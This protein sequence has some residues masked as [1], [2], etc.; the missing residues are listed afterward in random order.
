MSFVNELPEEWRGVLPEAMRSSG[1]LESVKTVEGLAK[2]AIDGRN[3]ASTALRIPSEDASVED[4]NAFNTD[5][6]SKMPN[7]V[8]MP[9]EGEDSAA[10]W[11]KLGRPADTDGYGIEKIPEQIQKNIAGLMKAGHDVGLSKKQME[12]ITK[13]IIDDFTSNVN[14]AKGRAEED[15]NKLKGEWGN[16]YQPK[17][18]LIK[19]FAEQTGFSEQFIDAIDDGQI[20]SKDMKAFDHIIKGFSGEGVN[21]GK[22]PG[23]SS[24]T[25]TP[26]EA[27]TRINEIMGNKD[28]AYWNA[29]DPSHKAAIDKIIALGEIAEK[30]R[31]L[32]ETERFRA[33]L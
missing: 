16:G 14:I 4:R 2:M 17:V 28:H 24:A 12:G 8:A 18:D 31:E 3:L 21:L 1:V 6:M 20:S 32:S 22:Q 29:S 11:D 33:S 7:L 30:G 5:L 23:D 9:G 10:M 27:Q 25:M 19:H 26:V 15:T 13:N